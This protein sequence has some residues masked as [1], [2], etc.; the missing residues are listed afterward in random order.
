MNHTSSTRKPAPDKK[1][2][3]VEKWIT[4]FKENPA[5]RKEHVARRQ[6]VG[7]LVHQIHAHP[8]REDVVVTPNFQVIVPPQRKFAVQSFLSFCTPCR[9]VRRSLRFDAPVLALCVDDLPLHFM[10]FVQKQIIA[11]LQQN[12]CYNPLTEKSKKMIHN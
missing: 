3:S 10:C 4:K 7:N 5:V 8:K 2:T 1:R 11:D 6:L 9:A 12:Q